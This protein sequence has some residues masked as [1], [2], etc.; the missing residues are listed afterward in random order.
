M[1]TI[2]TTLIND[3]LILAFEDFDFLGN[4]QFTIFI[5]NG[6]GSL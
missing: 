5:L 1:K 4:N 3:P 6:I 2:A